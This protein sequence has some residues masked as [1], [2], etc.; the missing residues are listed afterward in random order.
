M[1]DLEKQTFVNN[2]AAAWQARGGDAFLPCG[3][4]TGSCT[5]PSRIA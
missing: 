1:T 4:P 5:I 3:I 2:F